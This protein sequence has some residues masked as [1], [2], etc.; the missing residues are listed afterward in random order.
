MQ[1]VSYADG[2]QCAIC[3]IVKPLSEYYA[4]LG[5]PHKECK[6]CSRAIA[7]RNTRTRIEGRI[8][9]RLPERTG[10]FKQCSMCLVDKDKAEFP[11]D[12]RG[13]DGLHTQ[14]RSCRR[15]IWDGYKNQG[16]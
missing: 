14:C 12:P 6:E 9:R 4:R 2:Q 5:K 13:R 3:R 7:R 10:Q 16:N 11:A 1:Y 15:N 8:P